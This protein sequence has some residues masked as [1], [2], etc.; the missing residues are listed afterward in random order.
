MRVVCMAGMLMLAPLA[1][2]GDTTVQRVNFSKDKVGQLPA[3]WKAG[4]T[5]KADGSK[6]VYA[7]LPITATVHESFGLLASGS[8]AFTGLEGGTT[9]SPT[10]TNPLAVKGENVSWHASTTE[11]WIRLGQTSGNVRGPLPFT[12][13]LDGIRAGFYSGQ[14]NVSDD[15]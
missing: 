3:G 9:V 1:W 4:V 5:G 13:A 2:S 6:Y 10:G 7:D 15:I 14:I 8:L 12:V 11:S